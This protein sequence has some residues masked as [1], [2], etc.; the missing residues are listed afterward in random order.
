MSC[1]RDKIKIKI[2]IKVNEGEGDGGG[3]RVKRI[4]ILGVSNP[5]LNGRK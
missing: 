3:N 1:L 5:Q 4:K 2:T